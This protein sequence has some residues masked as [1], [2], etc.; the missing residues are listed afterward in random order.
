MGPLY[1]PLH[2]HIIKGNRISHECHHLRNRFL[3]LCLDEQP[4]SGWLIQMNFE[5]CPTVWKQCSETN[6]QRSKNF[7]KTLSSLGVFCYA[8]LQM[9][10]NLP[11]S[12]TVCMLLWT[13]GNTLFLLWLRNHEYCD[14]SRYKTGSVQ[15]F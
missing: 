12:V 5:I 6:R 4:T 3:C 15:T 8:F 14:I 1:W 9:H 2:D 13:A 10:C 7:L 11:W